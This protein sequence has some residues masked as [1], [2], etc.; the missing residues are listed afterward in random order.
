MGRQVSKMSTC[1]HPRV[2]FLSL[3]VGEFVSWQCGEKLEKNLMSTKRHALL[4]A[5]A[6]DE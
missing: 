3:E 2:A 6:Y 1:I 4:P 5:S